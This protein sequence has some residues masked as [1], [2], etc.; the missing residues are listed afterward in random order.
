MDPILLEQKINDV[1]I[2]PGIHTCRKRQFLRK[3][4]HSMFKVKCNQV[5]AHRVGKDCVSFGE[6]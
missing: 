6:R 4:R 5:I 3:Q 2:L 1:C